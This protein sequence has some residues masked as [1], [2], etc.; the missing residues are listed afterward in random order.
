MEKLVSVV[1]PCY[2][3]EA[4]IDTYFNKFL[5]QTYP[6][7]E[8]I[9]VNDGSTDR[10]EEKILSYKKQIEDRG[11]KL[12]YVKQMNGGLGAAINTGI[13][14]ITGDYFCWIDVDDYYENDAIENMVDFLEKNKEYPIG[15]GKI[16]YI[17][18]DT[19]E[20]LSIGA[21]K[22]VNNVDLFED[23]L[24]IK[25]DCYAFPAI[26]LVRT[27][28]FDK[29][30]KNRSI[31]PSRYG[32]DWQLLLPLLLNTKCG[33]LDKVVLNYNV[34]EN[35]MSHSPGKS[36]RKTIKNNNGHH[37]ILKHV[38]PELPIEDKQKNIYLKQIRK[39]YIKQNLK[40]IF[41]TPIK[42]L[43]KKIIP[44]PLLEKYRAIKNK[45]R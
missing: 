39:K 36:I 31:Y 10:S 41:I 14:K 3:G 42:Q 28:F 11:Y 32:Q 12:V 27:D 22:N 21:P 44:K 45:K 38:I 30:V 15:R 34:R 35:S 40:A 29:K 19:K 9:I 5:E 7:I 1:T 25:G 18:Y 4:F 24:F 8:I 20:I 13:K 23:Y 33:F 26:W 2:N 43:I 37:D 16:R 17:D 6:N